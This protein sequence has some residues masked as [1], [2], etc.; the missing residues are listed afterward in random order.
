MY[1]ENAEELLVESKEQFLSEYVRLSQRRGKGEYLYEYVWETNKVSGLQHRVA[2]LSGIEDYTRRDLYEFDFPWIQNANP[3]YTWSFVDSTSVSEEN[4]FESGI[5]FD[6]VCDAIDESLK[7]V[8]LFRS[9]DIQALSDFLSQ[10][11]T[12]GQVFGPF[13]VL[14]V[15]PYNL[16][17]TIDGRDIE[18]VRTWDTIQEIVDSFSA[19]ADFVADE[20]NIDFYLDKRPEEGLFVVEHN[21]LLPPESISEGKIGRAACRERV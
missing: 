14:G 6:N 8:E 9:P 20:N 21:L 12:I 19:F 5:S 3:G 2:R 7:I 10:G 1:G 13:T 18:M 15:A 17:I 4:F 16:K 11:L